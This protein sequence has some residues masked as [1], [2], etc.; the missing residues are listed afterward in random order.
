MI[1][2][3]GD[4]SRK[5]LQF[6]VPNYYYYRGHPRLALTM[7]VIQLDNVETRQM[8]GLGMKT[9]YNFASSHGFRFH[10]LAFKVWVHLDTLIF[11]K[12]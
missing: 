7:H 9:S 3:V 10:D 2:F 4:N 5:N 11:T 12:Y 8:V 6:F 1:R